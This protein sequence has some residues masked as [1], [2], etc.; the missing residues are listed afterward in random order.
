MNGSIKQPFSEHSHS[1]RGS[2]A[3]TAPYK[4][5]IGV[6]SPQFY[7]CMLPQWMVDGCYNE[8]QPSNQLQHS[9]YV[10]AQHYLNTAALYM[11]SWTAYVNSVYTL[12][13]VTINVAG[14]V[15]Q[16]HVSWSP[17]DAWQW[18]T[19]YVYQTNS[20]LSIKALAS[21]W[22]YDCSLCQQPCPRATL[23]AHH[24]WWYK[25]ASGQKLHSNHASHLTFWHSWAVRSVQICINRPNSLCT[26]HAHQ[27]WTHDLYWWQQGFT[28]NTK[29][30]VQPKSMRLCLQKHIASPCADSFLRVCRVSAALN[31]R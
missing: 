20:K 16:H 7:N 11:L 8:V 6:C 31:M 1:C 18:Y 25:L 13:S 26:I 10:T 27:G 15:G 4:A 23:Q 5:N 17:T 3:C 12:A 30:E 14:L 28:H 22:T 29:R 9:I 2:C 19:D 21:T 24:D